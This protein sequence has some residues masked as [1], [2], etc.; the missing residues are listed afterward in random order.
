MTSKPRQ[1]RRTRRPK[2]APSQGRMWPWYMAAVVVV[3]GI[4]I[5]DN[6]QHLEA[7]TGAPRQNQT[8]SQDTQRKPQVRAATALVSRTGSACQ[9]SSWE[10][11]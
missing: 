9:A 7:W 10:V 2:K 6:R 11:R 4:M 8:A 3:G 5:Y 1:K